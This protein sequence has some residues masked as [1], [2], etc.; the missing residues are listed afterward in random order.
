M[1]Y[2]FNI[3]ELIHKFFKSIIFILTLQR[4]GSRCFEISQL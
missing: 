4:A 1:S 3:P 2:K